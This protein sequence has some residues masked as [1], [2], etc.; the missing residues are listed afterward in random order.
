MFYCSTYLFYVILLHSINALSDLYL[1]N[2][3]EINTL[4]YH[5]FN[6]P[7]VEE[8]S[9]ISTFELISYC[10]NEQSFEF[11]IQPNGYNSNYSFIELSKRNITS[12]DLYSWFAPIDIIE[13]YQSYLDE[14]LPSSEGKEI[15]YN[16]TKERFGSMCQYEMKDIE[17]MIDIINSMKSFYQNTKPFLHSLTCYISLQC[18]R[19]S[20]CLDWSEICDGKIDCLDGSFDE[21]YCSQIEINDPI[22][23]LMSEY[24]T[25]KSI[26]PSVLIEDAKCRD[27]PLTSSC[28]LGRQEK[29][30]EELFS[31]NDEYVSDDCWSAFKC[32]LPIPDKFRSICN[33]FCER[34]ECLEIINDECPPMFNIPIIPIL[35]GN[36]YFAYEKSD[37]INF[38]STNFQ[39][40]YICY[41]NSLYDKYFIDNQMVFFNH[42]K[43][44]RIF[45]SKFP[46][47]SIRFFDLDYL[48]LIYNKFKSYM[49]SINYISHNDYPIIHCSND[50]Q[51]LNM[52]NRFLHDGEFMYYLCNN[53]SQAKKHRIPFEMICDRNINLLPRLINGQNETDET[54]CDSWSCNNIHTYCNGFWNCFNGDDELGCTKSLLLNSCSY[55]EYTCISIHTKQMIC[56]SIK[57]INDRQ[58]DCLDGSDEPIVCKENHCINITNLCE[59]W[60][61]SSMKNIRPELNFLSNNIISTSV[62]QSIQTHLCKQ[63]KLNTKMI[64]K[65]FENKIECHRGYP[66]HIWLNHDES[67]YICFCPDSY[68]GKTCEYQNERV[69]LS[70]QIHSYSD[71]RQTPFEILIQLIDNTNERI[72][73]SYV[74]FT[75]LFVRDC[76]IKFYY[77]LLYST[78]LKDQNKIYSIHIDIYEKKSSN[79]RGSLYFPILNNF[80]P[81]HRLNLTIQIPPIDFNGKKCSKNQCIHGKCIKYSNNDKTFCQCYPQWSGQYCSISYSFNYK[82]S[83]DS[84][85]LGIDAQNR[86]ICMCPLYK[87]GRRCF[88]K[89]IQCQSNNTEICNNHG[90]CI[91]TDL[92][93][94]LSYTC[95]CSKGYNGDHCQYENNEINLSFEKKFHFLQTIFIHFIKTEKTFISNRI[96]TFKTI[97]SMKDLINIHWSISIN[98]IL[99]EDFKK[100]YYFIISQKLSFDKVKLNKQ[101]KLTDRCLHLNELFNP[102]IVQYHFLHR[103]KYYQLPCQNST[104]LCFYDNVYLC[105]CYKHN[106]GQYL[107]NCFLFNHTTKVNCSDEN[108]CTNGGQCFQ[109]GSECLTKSTCLCHSCF[110][111]RRCQFSTSGFSLSLDNILGYHIQPTINLIKQSNIIQ[112]SIILNIIFTLIGLINGLLTLITFKNK[113]LRQVGCGLYLLSS[114]ITILIIVIL[115]ALK[116][117]ILIFVQISQISNRLFLQIQCITLDYFLRVFLHMD[118][119]LNACV[120]C[121]RAI[122]IIKSVRFSKRKSRKIAKII[123]SFILFFNILTFIHEPI[124]RHLIDEIDEDENEKRIWCTV[125]YSS[126]NLQ[127]YNSFIHTFHF[128]APFIINFVSALILVTKKSRQQSN[129]QIKR[130][131]KGILRENY[132]EHKHLF[133]APVLLVILALPRLIISYISKCM[134]S[135]NDSWLFLC[136]YFISFIPAM[137]TFLIFVIPSKFY[138]KAFHKTI[139]QYRRNIQRGYRC[140]FRV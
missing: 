14:L 103:I 79:Y 137:L 28:I 4:Q 72:I 117:W 8:I 15:F 12:D 27:L 129:I 108:E 102:T 41:N 107:T 61:N 47:T 38:N 30:F 132:Q 123:I 36:I 46:S 75:Y 99:I 140:V 92:N 13:R 60:N 101:V 9:S 51:I 77:Y 34:S 125:T 53:D 81:V 10:L 85:S 86:S 42:R 18:Y 35:F 54:E 26:L 11:H 113:S 39:D 17:S 91:P 105:L 37:S 32:I 96:T 3:N 68:Y 94:Q 119:W 112:I 43:C 57:K 49:K 139:I 22:Y 1:Y 115:F 65:R 106:N 6:L 88:L 73:H 44:Y 20:S 89:D 55:D 7:I 110:Y 131:F 64:G 135:I 80:L 130:S 24:D 63:E 90:E 111:G 33:H 25:V 50:N 59:N 100:N 133:L 93:R 97:S 71:S 87:F 116:F 16:C 76:K 23:E 120:A 78:R 66:I 118:Q 109:L 136:G 62:Q 127:T 45:I 128:F 5:C 52:N 19:G 124:H 122:T 40:P 95:I 98:L 58:I 2:T 82:C 84:K 74:K 126:S 56:L 83:S 114:S 21:E 29:L 104:L 69:S 67:T 70:F 134:E 31:I 48:Q 138:K 121:E